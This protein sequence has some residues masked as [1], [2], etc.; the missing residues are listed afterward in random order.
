MLRPTAIT[1][2]C[3]ALTSGNSLSA[4]PVSPAASASLAEQARQAS[5]T[6]RPVAPQAVAAARSDVRAAMAEL[7][8]FLRTGAP[9]KAVGW[10]RYLRW[11]ELNSATAGDAPPRE[12]I[13]A[14]REKL[15]AEQTGLD[16]PVFVRLR[17]ALD[18]YNQVAAAA[19]DNRVEGEFGRRMED[20]A[21]Q[22][23][24]YAKDQANSDAALAIGRGLGW[25][26][27]NQQ[28]PELVESV[29]RTYSHPNFLGRASYRFASVGV[30]RDIDQV[31][32]VRDNILGTD[33]HGTARMVGRS[34]L[35]LHDDPDEARMD[36]L[37]GGTAWS[38]NVGYNGPVTI[39]S[40]GTTSVSGRKHI[41]LNEQGFFTYAAQASCGTRSNIH[42]ICAKCG[43]IEKIAWKR[44]G[45]QQGEAEAIASQHAAGRVAGQMNNE[46]GSQIADANERYQTARRQLVRRGQ[47]PEDVT[48]SSM[49]DRIQVRMLQVGPEFIGAP[50]EPPGFG[51]EQDLALRAHESSVINYAAGL[52]GGVEL[53][54]LRLEKLIRDELKE[55]VPEELQVTRP[56]GTLDPDK[57]PWSIIFARELPVRVR[58][59]GGRLAIALRA[60]GFTRGEGEEP[61]K[62][63]PAITELVEIAANY[64]IERTDVGAT[65]RRD[66]DVQVRFPNRN[67]PDQITVRDSPI[68]TFMRRKFRSLFKEEFVGQGLMLKPPFDR[69]GTLRLA[70]LN[71]DGGWLVLGWQ[72]PTNPV[73]ADTVGGE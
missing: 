61:G 44:A 28:A 60:D 5:K 51:Q 4:Q 48:F 22:L 31:T 18:R 30:E 26:Q 49:P 65:L 29:R 17:E 38:N 2:A 63:R 41:M 35:T 58:F 73:A 56:D 55:E 53:T 12:V 7:D 19:G 6:F 43:L 64:T 27:A 23:D 15:L 71:V 8:A 36:I 66:G 34:T 52:L 69:A 1:L 11:D 59:N 13:S 47:F 3:L 21:A 72:M 10:K 33:L 20:L 70:E 57:E 54:D 9:Y 16:L 32:P 39:F 40:T 46:V 62:Y 68:V 45:Q 67:N 14:V 42:D 50:N 25:L 37:L 24:A